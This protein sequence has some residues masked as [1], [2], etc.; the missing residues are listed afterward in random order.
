MISTQTNR[1]YYVAL[2]K[3]HDLTQH[4]K[5]LQTTQ[6]KTKHTQ[7]NKNQLTITS[8]TQEIYNE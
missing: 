5:M 7:H 3:K 8:M 2:T 4:A 1:K 6:H